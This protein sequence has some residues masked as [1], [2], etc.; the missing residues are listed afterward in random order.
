MAKHIFKITRTDILDAVGCHTT[1]RANSTVLDQ[2]LFVADK[3]AWDQ[4]PLESYIHGLKKR[5]KN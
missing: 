1:L 2:V 4:A 5:M 3:I